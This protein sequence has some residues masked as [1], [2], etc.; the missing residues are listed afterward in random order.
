[1][2]KRFDCDDKERLVAYLYGEST[3]DDRRAIDSHL[4]SCRD[5]AAEVRDLQGV[6]TTLS[7]WE[8]P[9]AELGF[10]IVREPE[11]VAPRRWWQMPAWAPLALAAGLVLA[12]AASVEVEYGGGSVTVRTGWARSAPSAVA[13]APA[14]APAGTQLTEAQLG[15]ALAALEGKLRAE[16]VSTT[17]V[18]PEPVPTPARAQTAGVDRAELIRQVEQLIELSERRQQRELAFRLAQVVQD[19]DAAHRTDMVRIENGLG[20]IEGLTGQE[21]ARQ[22]QLINYLM[23]TAS[24]QR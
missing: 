20:Q 21:V 14:T 23:R 10:R 4:E 15:A 5:C 7:A 18:P 24:Q 12:L 16:F 17:S 13:T 11:A 1:M 8:P 2:T 19:M 3:S 9:E 6:R 22:Q